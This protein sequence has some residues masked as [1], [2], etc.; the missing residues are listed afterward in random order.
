LHLGTT[1]IERYLKAKHP[2]PE[3]GSLEPFIEEESPRAVSARGPDHV[4]HVDLTTVPV[5]GATAANRKPRY[6]PRRQ[7]PADSGCV[8]PYAE[9][10]PEQGNH[11]CL[12]LRFADAYK[13]LLIVE[14]R[15]VA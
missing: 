8:A 9:P 10:R 1:T 4:W 7:W 5:E 11:L 13:R 12:V 14:L 2:K 3:S 15:E 6:E